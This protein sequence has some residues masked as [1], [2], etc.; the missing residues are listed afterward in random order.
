MPADHDSLMEV[1]QALQRAQLASDVDALEQLLHNHLRFIGPDTG[2]HDKAED[3]AAHQAGLVAF[4]SSTPVEFEVHAY[5][6]TGVTIALLELEVEVS[7]ELV[8]GTCRYTRTWLCEDD[9]WQ[10]VAGAVVA[11]PAT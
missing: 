2:V 4:K 1:E 6:T 7:G 3:L 8:H 9:R 11:V 10:I 5:G